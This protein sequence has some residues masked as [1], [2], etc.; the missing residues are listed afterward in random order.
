MKA[1]ATKNEPISAPLD[2]GPSCLVT[3][4]PVIAIAL[5]IN[6]KSQLLRIKNLKTMFQ[7]HIEWATISKAFKLICITVQQLYGLRRRKR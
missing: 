5:K 1:F 3:R 4:L 2:S 6:K 7:I